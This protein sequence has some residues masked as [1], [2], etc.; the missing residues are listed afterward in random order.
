MTC[1]IRW[2]GSAMNR[3][4]LPSVARPRGRSTLGCR[5]RPSST[6]AARESHDPLAP[7]SC[8]ELIEVR[9]RTRSGSGGA[10]HTGPFGGG[11]GHTVRLRP[12]PDMSTTTAAAT[13]TNARR[14]LADGRRRVGLWI[15]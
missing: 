12:V 5:F 10:G 6:P 1:T 13:E 3:R 9:N 4:P 2:S 14:R 8:G 11:A 7:M 15:I